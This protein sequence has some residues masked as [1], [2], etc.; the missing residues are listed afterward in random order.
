MVF[1]SAKKLL[2]IVF[3][4]NIF[5]GYYFYLTSKIEFSFFSLLFGF[6]ILLFVL[7]KLNPYIV[8]VSV[9]GA[10]QTSAGLLIYGKIELVIILFASFLA[11]ETILL[12]NVFAFKLKHFLVSCI[13]LS[14]FYLTTRI[15][16]NNLLS[17]DFFFVL[18]LLF[19]CFVLP[20]FVSIFYSK[21]DFVFLT[22]S[23]SPKWAK[24]KSP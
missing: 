22:K 4:A 14:T 12:R 17:F 21:K 11:I 16:F 19:F 10:I 3:L 9:C 24:K 7:E 20:F 8:L 23:F 18:E 15:Y 13:F 6:S 5:L 1:F 2:L